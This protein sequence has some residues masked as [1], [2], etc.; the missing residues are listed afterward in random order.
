MYIT[1]VEVVFT[2]VSEDVRVGL[3]RPFKAKFD[4]GRVIGWAA[5]WKDPAPNVGDVYKVLPNGGIKFMKE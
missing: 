4:N 2:P 3:G 1:I 5:T